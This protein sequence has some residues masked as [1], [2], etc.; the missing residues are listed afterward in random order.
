VL[1]TPARAVCDKAMD[2]KICDT[3]MA[4][5]KHMDKNVC[6]AQTSSVDSIVLGLQAIEKAKAVGRNLLEGLGKNL[7]DGLNKAMTGQ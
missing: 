6:E 5:A 4:K 1:R 3:F 2:Q 7:Q